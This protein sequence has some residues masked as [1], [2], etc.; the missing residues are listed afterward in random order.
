MAG[1]LIGSAMYITVVLILTMC[2]WTFSLL[3][4]EI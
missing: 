2:E 1:I 4:I 3:W